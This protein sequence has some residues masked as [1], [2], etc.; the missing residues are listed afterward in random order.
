MKESQGL[1]NWLINAR[2]NAAGWKKAMYAFL[3]LLVVLNI[4]IIPHHPHVAPEAI[5]GFWAAFGFLGAVVMTFVLKKMVF[6]II[7]RK[8]E[9]YE[10]D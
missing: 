7:S 2:K 3:I 9:T 1:A 5:P 8:E 6:P 10:R 4:F